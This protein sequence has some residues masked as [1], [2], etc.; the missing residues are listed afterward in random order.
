[1]CKTSS[2]PD[3]QSI[4]AGFYRHLTNSLLSHFSIASDGRD[5]LRIGVVDLDPEDQGGKDYQV[6]QRSRKG[7]WPMVDTFDGIILS[8]LTS[9]NCSWSKPLG[10]IQDQATKAGI[11][12]ASPWDTSQR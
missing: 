12:C 10:C 9:D 1:M 5:H 6:E 8:K 7:R 3:S 4:M 2:G 11:L